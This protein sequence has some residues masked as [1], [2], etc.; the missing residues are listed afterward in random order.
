MH[1]DRLKAIGIP[2][3]WD[4][5]RTTPSAVFFVCDASKT[6]DLLVSIRAA[7]HPSSRGVRPKTKYFIALA[8]LAGE[9]DGSTSVNSDMAQV[10]QG[11]EDTT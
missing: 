6:A 1:G 8:D 5:A 2:P 7:P 3:N 4:G 9:R 10:Q 11:W